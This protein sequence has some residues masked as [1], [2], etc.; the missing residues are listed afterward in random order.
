MG[1]TGRLP[2]SYSCA[3]STN[4]NYH[5]QIACAGMGIELIADMPEEVTTQVGSEWEAMLPSA[6]ADVARIFES[7]GK[8]IAGTGAVIQTNTQQIWVNSS[9]IEI[10]LT[11]TFEA[12]TSGFQDVVKPI[13]FLEKLTMPTIAFGGTTLLSP[14]PNRTGGGMEVRVVIGKLLRLE[15]AILVSAAGSFSSRMAADGY[16]ISGRCDLT[17]RTDRVLSREQ[18]AEY[19]GTADNV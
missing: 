4:T 18:W 2:I 19:T 17:I 9:P 8:V 13:R 11:L 16:P 10:P 14:G 3:R 1:A 5:V 7:G 12:E 15:S 6:I